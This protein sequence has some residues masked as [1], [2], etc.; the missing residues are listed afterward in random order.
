MKKIDEN[1]QKIDKEAKKSLNLRK[2][3]P[4]EQKD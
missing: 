4:S 3:H 2:K 1:A